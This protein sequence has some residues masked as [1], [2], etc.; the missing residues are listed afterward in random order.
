MLRSVSSWHC[1]ASFWLRRVEAVAG[2]ADFA[3]GGD[4]AAL[5]R[6]AVCFIGE[7]QIGML[8]GDRRR[9]AGAAWA[10]PGWAMAAPIMS[11]VG[12]KRAD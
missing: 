3:G 7:V 1:R 8:D 9:L 6:I 11:A 2:T 5:Q 10:V 4:E 12:I